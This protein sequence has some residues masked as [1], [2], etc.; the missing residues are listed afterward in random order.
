[1]KKRLLIAD[2]YIYLPI[3]GGKPETKIEIFCEE[4]EQEE[5]FLE[6]MVPYEDND[7]EYKYDYE[8]R[9]LVEKFIG[10]TLVVN[11]QVSEAFM[12]QII[13]GSK[14]IQ[15]R[16]RR[17]R[18]HFTPERR[19]MNDPNGLIFDNG[20]YH[21]YFQYN[22][23]NIIWN[24]MCWGHAI[25][26]DL[27]HW[28]EKDIVM[29]P[30]ENGMMFSGSAMKNERRALGL[31]ETAI[32]YFYTAAGDE[33]KNTKF[34]QRMAYSLDNGETLIKLEQPYLENI[35]N[36]NRDPKVF[37][38][39]ESQSYIMS[40]WLE[41]SDF[42][43]L[44]SKDLVTWETTDHITMEGAWECPDLICLK[45]KG[46]EKKWIFW[47]ADG[48][49]LPGDFDGY[50]FTV[51]GPKKCAYLGKL[52]YAAQTYSGI[53]D[54]VIS[55]PWLRTK[56]RNN[57]YTGTMGIP[58]EMSY[59]EKNGTTCLLQ[60]PV[61]EVR[62]QGELVFRMNKEQ[63]NIYYR[64]SLNEAL[65][66]DIYLKT[67]QEKVSG[68]VNGVIFEYQMKTGRY[69]SGEQEFQIDSNQ[70]EFTLLLDRN[71]CEVFIGHGASMAIFEI[72]S[73][74]VEL[75]INAVQCENLEIR[76]II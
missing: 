12:N 59:E 21:L 51:S 9:I 14:E 68:K 22:P 48:Y 6:I 40:L 31:P 36:E 65:L 3:K 43:I 15:S 33:T 10:Q 7:G 54:R 71:V 53:E 34:T 25:S 63:E 8:A 2:K 50:H 16:K 76:R 38:H 61:R 4:K 19:W 55:I 70:T 56:C 18:I 46:E 42:I 13:N 11:G 60:Y 39:E 62:E 58:L 45:G 64:S 28:K 35:V 67:E 41:N 66:I 49:Y 74:E 26:T 73:D 52:A 72:E 47:S 24:N 75:V 32:L 69:K 27:L 44:R 37:W 29:L 20:V 1:M 57:E 17:P 5:N 30:D 23:F